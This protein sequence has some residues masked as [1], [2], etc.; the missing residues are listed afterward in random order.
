[1]TKKKHKKAKQLR[2]EKA[3]V[4]DSLGIAAR[5]AQALRRINTFEID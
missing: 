1:M 2:M 4:H 5:Y 3:T